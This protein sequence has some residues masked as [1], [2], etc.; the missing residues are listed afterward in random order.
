MRTPRLGLPFEARSLSVDAV[1]VRGG[2]RYASHAY[3]Y[4]APFVRAQQGP[5][6]DQVHVVWSEPVRG[7]I[8]VTARMD[9]DV[10]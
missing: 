1:V 2:V 10:V 5:N 4:D 8:A 7:K 3:N 6:A 9:N